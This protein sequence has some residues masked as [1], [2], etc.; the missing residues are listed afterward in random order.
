MDAQELI[1]AG[2]LASK[3][4]NRDAI[5]MAV[6]GG[7]EDLKAP[8][9][10]SKIKFIPF[11]PVNKPTEAEIKGSDGKR[12]KVTKG[13]PQIILGLCRADPGVLPGVGVH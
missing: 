9:A 10:F 13:A 8:E 5:D 7:L 1:L 6:I 11:D 4:E 2:A 3:F 12:F